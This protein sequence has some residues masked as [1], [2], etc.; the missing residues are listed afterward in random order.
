MN[1]TLMVLVSVFAYYCCKTWVSGIAFSITIISI[2]LL[3]SL[4]LGLFPIFSGYSRSWIFVLQTLLML[5]VLSS[6]IF[7]RHDF[8]F[9]IAHFGM[10]VA[11]SGGFWGAC[12]QTSEQVL[13]KDNTQF[14]VSNKECT[15]LKFDKEA[16]VA[17]LLTDKS[18][19]LTAAV[20]HPAYYK[21]RDIY[22]QTYNAEHNVCVLLVV[23]QPW[24]WVEYAGILLMLIWAMLVPFKIINKRRKRY[25]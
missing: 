6:V 17:Y 23:F 13:L 16:Q 19:T 9:F 24:K 18:D 8:M 10:L 5:F 4:C 15:F 7:R 22:P 12:D 25:V 3:L 1:V 14:L 21:G 11:V 2:W 20:N